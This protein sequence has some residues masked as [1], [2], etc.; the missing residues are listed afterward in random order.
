[1][2]LRDL[3][4]PLLS[5]L[6]LYYFGTVLDLYIVLDSFLHL[7][8]L[9]IHLHYKKMQIFRR[10]ESVGNPMEIRRNMILPT[11]FRPT[12]VGNGPSEIVGQKLPTEENSVGNQSEN[13]DG[14]IR[15]KYRQTYI[16]PSEQSVRTIDGSTDRFL[17]SVM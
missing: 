17:P 6:V 2:P 15:R 12:L 9:L 10:K 1:M 8:V 5:A 14:Q 16:N 7:L 3:L 13:S 4:S 11:D